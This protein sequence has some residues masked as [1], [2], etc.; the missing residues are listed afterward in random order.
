MQDDGLSW[1][2]N[3]DVSGNRLLGHKLEQAVLE[4]LVGDAAVIQERDVRFRGL[5]FLHG[6]ENQ[7]NERQ[8]ADATGMGGPANASKRRVD[9]EAFGIRPLAGNESEGPSGH[10]EQGRMRGAVGVAELAYHYASVTGEVE[11]GAVDEAN[12]DPPVG[13]G[14]DH[15]ALAN[16]IADHDLNGNAVRSTEGAATDRRLNIAGDL[17]REGQNALVPELNAGRNEHWLGPRLMNNSGS[18]WCRSF[19]VWFCPRQI[20]QNIMAPAALGQPAE[21]PGL[22]T[23][24]IQEG[25]AFGTTLTRRNCIVLVVR[26]GTSIKNS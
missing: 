26:C 7:G 16:G 21:P 25:D 10:L 4:V 12:S 14:L 9:S 11:N 3:N 5:A 13:G 24:S 23:Q 15:V 22:I 17:G 18:A 6:R 1:I 20:D 8:H 2:L 19:W